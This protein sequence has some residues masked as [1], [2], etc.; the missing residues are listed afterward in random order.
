MG[1][2]LPSSVPFLGGEGHTIDTVGDIVFNNYQ[3][4]IAMYPEVL[5]KS[6]QPKWPPQRRV[7]SE[8]LV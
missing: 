3:T 4:H 5:L 6:S 2:V 8:K 7:P 1:S